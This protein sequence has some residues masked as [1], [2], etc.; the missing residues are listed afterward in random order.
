MMLRKVAVIGLILVVSGLGAILPAAAQD[1]I[2]YRGS[3]E[4]TN[5][6]T[7][8]VTI[9]ATLFD[10]GQNQN[11]GSSVAIATLS[12]GETFDG[13]VEN[14]APDGTSA[15][16]AITTENLSEGTDLAGAGFITATAIDRCQLFNDGRLNLLDAA[17]PVIVYPDENSTEENPGYSFYGVGSNGVGNEIFDLAVSTIS[18]VV[19]R[20]KANGENLLVTSQ[21]GVAVY[22]LSSG[23]CQMNVFQPDGKLYEFEWV[24]VT[25]S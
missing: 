18:P 10:V 16:F 7:E 15:E 17:A 2:C 5:N 4:Y 13:D 25:A 20:A 19:D 6:S 14:A 23:N 9:Y 21:S 12:P 1:A 11:L 24:C 8:D 22:A 3:L